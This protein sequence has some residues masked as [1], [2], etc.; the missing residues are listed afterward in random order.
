[1]Q[2]ESI[3]AQAV[4]L[5]IDVF[6]NTTLCSHVQ[7]QIREFQEIWYA[8]P[9]HGLP[10][11]RTYTRSE[12]KYREAVL[13]DFVS[14]IEAEDI[15]QRFEDSALQKRLFRK[16]RSFFH[17]GL[18]FGESHLNLIMSPAYKSSTEKFVRD[19][20]SFDPSLS[21]AD[22]FQACRNVWIMN[23]LQIMLG[24]PVRLTVSMFAYSL[25]YPY[26]DNFID[27][28]TIPNRDKKSFNNR[29]A[30]RLA[31][32]P[33]AARNRH[34]EIIYSLVAM[35]ENEFDRAQ[36]PKVFE[37]LLAIH[38]AQSLSVDLFSPDQLPDDNV[39]RISLEKGGTSV[40]AD[41]Y[42]VAGAL[43]QDQERFM[44]G[45]GAYLQFLDDLQDVHEDAQAGQQ[46]V[47]TSES[48]H[49]CLDAITTQTL[50]FGDSA[51]SGEYG[52]TSPDT[53]Q[54]MQLMRNSIRLMILEAAGFAQDRFT[55]PYIRILESYS[56]FRFEELHAIKKEHAP[57]YASIFGKLI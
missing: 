53:P 41:G 30:Q 55:T 38:Q 26:T 12:Q 4:T 7:E 46:S 40:L 39:L 54:Y 45:Y 10:F 5:P 11:S 43:T 6:Q 36:Y 31:G 8:S 50:N 19:A 17:S 33:I 56:P 13:R 48:E 1:M 42:L 52:F 21:P 44:F 20:K 16:M 47:Y 24:L 37:S 9:R 35:I 57:Y 22:L 49:T 3:M 23:G 2:L 28:V 29:F 25:L 32:F 18:D 51:L 34:E 14:Q 27:D 15:Q